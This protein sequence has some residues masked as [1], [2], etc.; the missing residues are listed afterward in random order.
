MKDML[1]PEFGKKLTKEEI[2]S[3]LDIIQQAVFRCRDI[4]RK[5]LTFVR[6][7]DFN[8]QP[9]EIHSLIDEVVEDF[10][11]RELTVSNIQIVRNYCTAR[12]KIITDK[13]QLQ[14]VFINLINNAIDAIPGTGKISITTFLENRYVKI[15]VNDTGKGMTQDQL[16]KIFMPFYT[17]KNVGKGTGLGLSISYGIIKSLDGEISVE[18]TVGVGTSFIIKLPVEEILNP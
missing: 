14:Q 3:Q 8:L 10:Y 12:P 11:E 17:T 4:T 6:K 9:C 2:T 5:L 16:E 15:Q 18:S 1:T 7:T 13:N